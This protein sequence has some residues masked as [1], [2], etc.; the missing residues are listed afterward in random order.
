MICGVRVYITPCVQEQHFAEETAAEMLAGR[1][2]GTRTATQ[3]S[4]HTDTPHLLH[5]CLP[6]LHVEATLHD[7]EQVLLVR[8]SVGLHAAIQPAGGAVGGLL[9][10]GLVWKAG[11]AEQS[12]ARAQGRTQAEAQTG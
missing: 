4:T 5:A 3:H 8:V 10:S 6:Q 7:G 9:K 2:V 1:R 11:A 12:R